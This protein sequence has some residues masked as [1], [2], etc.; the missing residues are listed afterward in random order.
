MRLTSTFIS[1]TNEALATPVA[2]MAEAEPP[3]AISFSL[4]MRSR[5]RALA[6]ARTTDVFMSSSLTRLRS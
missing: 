1:S 3:W 4:S 2:P 6:S 5:P